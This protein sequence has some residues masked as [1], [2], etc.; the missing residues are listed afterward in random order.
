[1]DLDPVLAITSPTEELR[2]SLFCRFL[3]VLSY[4]TIPELMIE[5]TTSPDSLSTSLFS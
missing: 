1:M 3:F 2:V 5:F 4:F